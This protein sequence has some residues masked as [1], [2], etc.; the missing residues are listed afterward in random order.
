MP[1]KTILAYL[2]SPTIARSVLCAAKKV[3]EA[4]G[5]HIIGLHLEPDMMTYGE[6][7]L[8]IS[9]EVRKQLTRNSQAATAA[10]KTVFEESLGTTVPKH[11]WRSYTVPY[12]TGE[13]IIVA[14]AGSAD[15]VICGMNGGD[16]ASPWANLTEAVLVRG[17]RPVLAIPSPLPVA[18]IGDQ[19]IIAWNGTR[20]AVRA[21]FDSLDLI[22]NAS[23]VRVITF[24]E[25]ENQRLLAELSSSDIVQALL[26]HGIPA[27]G[28]VCYAL[29]GDAAGALVSSLICE[30]CDLLVMG[31]YSHSR[32][33]EMIF[34]GM[35]REMMSKAVVP[36]LL[37]H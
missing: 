3:A 23:T 30:G 13:D 1:I 37:S 7:N 20:E 32:R 18:R 4:Q 19:V 25:D 34:G 10:V 2:S 24:M 29:G 11:E 15:L 9:E 6:S 27:I 33:T 5:V 31:G 17:G 16:E 28:D 14:A 22:R 12:K 21:V 26:R 8:Q 35:S 36:T